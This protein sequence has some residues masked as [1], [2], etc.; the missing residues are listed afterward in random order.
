MVS[1]PWVLD[2]VFRALL[3]FVERPLSACHAENRNVQALVANKT[4]KSGKDLLVCEVAT[5]A[6]KDERVGREFGSGCPSTLSTLVLLLKMSAK[7]E[8]HG[9]HELVGEVCVA[10]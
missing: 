6:E 2:A 7:F 10:A 3:E 5:G 8:A 4:K 1:P 9:G